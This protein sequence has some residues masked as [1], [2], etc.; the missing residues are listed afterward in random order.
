MSLS[1]EIIGFE[2]LKRI[3]LFHLDFV[4]IDRAN[5]LKFIIRPKEAGHQEPHCHVEFGSNN[6]SISLI[7]FEVL[8][9][10]IPSHKQTEAIEWVK[11]NLEVIKKYW[12]EY[13][14]I[15]VA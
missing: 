12:N 7:S 10:N 13:H 14:E 8:A 5:Q 6:I 2:K 3:L 4:V 9:G 15:H 1:E 11:E